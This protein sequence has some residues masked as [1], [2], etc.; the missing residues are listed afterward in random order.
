MWYLL[1]NYATNPE[2]RYILNNTELYFIPCVNPDGYIRNEIEEPGGGGF[3]RKNMRDNQN[4]SFGVD[5]NR[6][7]GFQWG[8]D[9][10]G[11]SSNSQSDTYRGPS[12]FSE[13]ETRI[14]KTFCEARN[15]KF[16]LNYH[17]FSNL[18]IYP[19]AWSD[20]VA[21]AKFTEYASLLVAENNYLAGVATQTVGYQVNGSSDDYMFGARNIVA[22]T[23][24][25]GPGS[26]GFW[27][28]ASDIDKLNKD[29]LKLNLLTSQLPLNLAISNNESINLTSANTV[30]FNVKRFGLASGPFQVTVLPKT[31]ASGTVTTSAQQITL[32]QFEQRLMTFAFTPGGTLKNGDT[33]RFDIVINN[34]AFDRVQKVEVVYTG[35]LLNIVNN[36]LTSIAGFQ[37]TNPAN[38]KLTTETFFSAPTSCA[39]SP[40]GDYSDNSITSI[41]STSPVTIPVTAT[42]ARY[43][44]KQNGC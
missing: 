37:S 12:A 33:L 15:F 30:T 28:P 19:W 3:W 34:G 36:P 6:N 1:E 22:F 43:F 42:A 13:P 21:D 29:A 25:V 7:Y 32:A 35:Q 10:I 9:N 14:M 44:F 39:D 41:I 17:T 24:E 31:P 4:G 20:E 18:L 40:G 16:A 11:S 5:L 2:I 27:P 8:H 26:T 38:W 23:P